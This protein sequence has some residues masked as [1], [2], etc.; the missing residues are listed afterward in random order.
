MKNQAVT[1]ER[2]GMVLEHEG[3]VEGGFYTLKVTADTNDADLV[4]E[5]KKYTQTEADEWNLKGLVV[6]L[7]QMKHKYFDDLESL[8][9]IFG[10]EYDMLECLGIPHGPGEMESHSVYNVGLSYYEDGNTYRFDPSQFSPS[11]KRKIIFDYLLNQDFMQGE[12]KADVELV[13]AA[14]KELGRRKGGC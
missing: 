7:Y 9:E 5:V 1:I 11:E 3:S 10:G 13:N 2:N 12:E 6:L 8:E 4:S 14:L